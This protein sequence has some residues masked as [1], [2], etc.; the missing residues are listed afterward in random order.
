VLRLV[1]GG[2][3]EARDKPKPDEPV[4]EA[5]G[6]NVYAKQLVDGHDRAQLVRLC[7]AIP[8]PGFHMIR[9]FGVLSSHSAHRYE[10]VPLLAEPGRFQTEPAEGDQLELE[11]D[12]AAGGGAK[13]SGRSRWET[14]RRAVA[15]EGRCA[16]SR[17]RPRQTPSDGYWPSTG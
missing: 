10:V 11:W 2:A 13:S 9:Y 6:V 3:Q 8:P 7:A 17:Q 1:A 5:L 15:V 16:G 12:D 14:L 4:A